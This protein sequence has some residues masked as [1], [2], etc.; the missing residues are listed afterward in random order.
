M[1]LLLVYVYTGSSVQPA[2]VVIDVNPQEMCVSLI[3]VCPALVVTDVN[4]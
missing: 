2:L 1:Y 4:P 3:S